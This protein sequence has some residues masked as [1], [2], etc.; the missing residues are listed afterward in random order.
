MLTRMCRICYPHTLLVAMEN[1]ITIVE[2]SLMVPKNV[3][4]N[5][6]FQTHVYPS[7]TKHVHE[8]T[9]TEIFIIVLFII[10]KS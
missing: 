2:N 6:Q 1:D 3:R 10:A 7:E 9:C 8:E 4:V 5:Q